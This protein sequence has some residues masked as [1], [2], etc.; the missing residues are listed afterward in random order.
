MYTAT[1]IGVPSSMGSFAPGQEKAPAALRLAGLIGRLR[2]AGVDVRDQGDSPVRR[3]FPDREHPSAQHVT[4]VRDVALETADRVAGADGIPLVLGGDCTIGL[5]TLA[6]LQA[7]LEGRVGL[8]YFDLH[9][10]GNVPASVREGAL[11]WMGL[12]HAL[13]L[14]GADP[15]LS[16]AFARTPLLEA[17]DL[18]LFSTKTNTDF[19]EAWVERLGVGRTMVEEV[20]S[21][22]VGS[23]M[24]ALDAFALRVDHLAV[25]FDVDVVDFMDLPLSEDANRNVGLTFEAATSAL[26]TIM[27]HPAAAALTVCE[28]NPDHDPDGSELPR[29]IDGLVG[30]LAGR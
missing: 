2:D 19:E 9:S 23:A 8:F 7:R 18:W 5:G 26:A 20:A 16:K 11:D 4:A 12:G 28:L 3:W 13:G 15:L 17:A 1:V 22:P 21:D 6:G 24:K 25:H 14:E 10:D 27:A 30:A 29:F